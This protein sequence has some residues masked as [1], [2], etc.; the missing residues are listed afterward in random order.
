MPTENTRFTD[1]LA[2]V[3]RVCGF[4]MLVTP[5]DGRRKYVF[6]FNTPPTPEDRR[7]MVRALDDLRR[8]FDTGWAWAVEEIALKRK[9]HTVLWARVASG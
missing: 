8:E 9:A 4:C 3:G 5:R 7:F 1:R 6:L 2:E